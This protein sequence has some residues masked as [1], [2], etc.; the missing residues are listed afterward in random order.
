MSLSAYVHIPFCARKCN[1]CA[2]YSAAPSEY[3]LESYVDALENQIRN[4]SSKGEKLTSVFFG[5]GTPSLLKPRLFL[6][7]L[8][9]LNETFDLTNAEITTELNPDSVDNI[10]DSDVFLRF[11]RFSMGV[12]S[13][14]DEELEILGRLHDSATAVN[15]FKK[16]RRAGAENINIDLM[17][18]LPGAEHVKKIENTLNTAISLSP[19]HIS[20]YILTP[21][22]GTPLYE[23][24]GNF[25]DDM[26][27]DI[28]RLVCDKLA[29]EGYEHYEISNFA[30]NG[31]RCVHNMCYWTQQKYLAFG[32]SAC[33]F[34]GASRFRIDCTTEE[35]IKNK[36]IVPLTVEETLSD[37]A[38]SDEKIMLSLRLSDGIDK[39]T[40]D[41]LS[42]KN[43]KKMFIQNLL[44]SSLARINDRGGLSL[45][46][47]GFLVSN[48]IIRNLI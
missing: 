3:Q 34:D 2:F 41:K 33:G 18:A 4:S 7:I 32:P 9:A 13:F 38:L 19:E 30:K 17:L 44:S 5:G 35:F 16:L 28:Y 23:K 27:P 11:T 43:S 40:L 20:A 15:A 46:D 31:R 14:D 24:F 22:H 1:Y 47:S 42:L 45:T 25:N 12:Q 6:R 21:E 39:E 29:S 37:E 48:E 10:L 8:D 36:G 26:A